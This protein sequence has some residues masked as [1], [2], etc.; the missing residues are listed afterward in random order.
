MTAALLDRLSRYTIKDFISRQAYTVIEIKYV[1]DTSHGK[2][3]SR[4]MH[5]DIETYRHHPFCRTILFFVY[6]PES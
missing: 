5:D 3:I 4:E 2:H 6:D 1:R